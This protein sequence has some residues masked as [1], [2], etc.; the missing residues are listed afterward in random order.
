MVTKM[1]LIGASPYFIKT[2]LDVQTKLRRTIERGL[3][4]CKLRVF[5]DLRVDLTTYFI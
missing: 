1:E 4:N 2:S 5:L 3:L